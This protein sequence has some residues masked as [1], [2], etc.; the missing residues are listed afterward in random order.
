LVLDSASRTVLL[1][2]TSSRYVWLTSL[3]RWFTLQPGANALRFDGASG[4]GSCA[5]SFRSAWI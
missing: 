5:V 3:S 4:A 1:G 2:G